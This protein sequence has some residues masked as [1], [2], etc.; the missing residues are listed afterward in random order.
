MGDDGEE[1]GEEGAGVEEGEEDGSTTTLVSVMVGIGTAAWR[2]KISKLPSS[3]IT[4]LQ[5]IAPQSI[6]PKELTTMDMLPLAGDV[7]M[8]SNM[9][10]FEA[11]DCENT[12]GGLLLL[13]LLLRL[14]RR[15]P[16]SGNNLAVC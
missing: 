2:L 9:F 16:L 5:T 4:M 15:M 1:G 10:D 8:A 13:L 3:T 11:A 6:M 14:T 7:P 12:M